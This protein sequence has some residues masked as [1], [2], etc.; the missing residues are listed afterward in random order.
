MIQ[1]EHTLVYETS[2]EV[3]KLESFESNIDYIL[4]DLNTLSITYLKPSAYD[5]NKTEMIIAIDRKA[6]L[7]RYT[8]EIKIP[9]QSF[10]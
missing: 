1:P 2:T 5:D 6:Y 7:H 9:K 3:F 8:K 10:A 4:D